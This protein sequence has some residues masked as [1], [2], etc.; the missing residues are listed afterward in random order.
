M[1]NPVKRS[2][3]GSSSS[4]SLIRLVSPTR[5]FRYFAVEAAVL[6]RFRQVF[7]GHGFRLT[8]I[9]DG[10]RYLQQAVARAG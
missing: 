5:Q 9:G 8:G 3:F 10:A 6:D 2:G 1:H 4:G 7:G